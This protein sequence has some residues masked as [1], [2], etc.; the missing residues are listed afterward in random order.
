PGQVPARRPGRV[1]GRGSGGDA[2]VELP[3]AAGPY[4][5]DAGGDN[6]EVTSEVPRDPSGSRTVTAFSENGDV[7]IRTAN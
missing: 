7:A 3:A 5:V 6:G 4:A 1:E 2:L